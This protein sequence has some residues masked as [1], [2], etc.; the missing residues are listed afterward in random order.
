MESSKEH[1]KIKFFDYNVKR[2]AETAAKGTRTLEDWNRQVIAGETCNYYINGVSLSVLRDKK[3]FKDVQELKEFFKTHLFNKMYEIKKKT[4]EDK[5]KP[6]PVLSKEERAAKKLRIEK[7]K[8]KREKAAER[9]AEQACLQ[10]HQAGIQHAT[11]QNAW[12]LSEQQN[13]GIGLP[14]PTRPPST[15]KIEFSAIPSG[16]KIIEEN[17]FR[18][19]IEK[20]HKV[21]EQI[22]K[23]KYFAKTKSTYVFT[24]T[25]IEVKEVVIDCPTAALTPV[26][27]KKLDGKQT[28]VGKFISSLYN[29]VSGFSSTMPKEIPEVKQE[30]DERTIFKLK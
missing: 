21:H 26:F 1:K 19:W 23:E 16:V 13:I 25:E 9:A 20:Q 2:T 15:T 22:G 6:R 5:D 14:D 7:I 3:P 12:E 18:K 4:P 28:S 17:I 8:A 30:E 27:G 29:L 10:M 24:P 11:Y